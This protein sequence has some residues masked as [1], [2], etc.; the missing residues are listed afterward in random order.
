MAKCPLTSKTLLGASRP[1]PRF[2]DSRGHFADQSE[3]TCEV[4]GHGRRTSC[5]D[6]YRRFWRW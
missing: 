1:H 5:F 4:V 6:T 2:A 3:V